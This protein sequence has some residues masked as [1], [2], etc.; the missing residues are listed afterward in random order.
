VALEALRAG[1]PVIATDHSGLPEI[2]RHNETGL[3]APEGDAIGLADA[4]MQ[5]AEKPEALPALRGAGQECLTDT[6]DAAKQ[7]RKLEERFLAALE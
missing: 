6:F 7:S 2:I 1:A 3:V 4:M 5:A